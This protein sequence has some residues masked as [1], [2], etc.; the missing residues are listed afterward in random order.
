VGVNTCKGEGWGLVNFEHAACRVAQVVPDHTSCKEIFEGYGRLIRC[1]HVDVDTNFARE[2]P[3]PSAVHL[4][5]ILNELYEDRDKLDAVAELCYLR[6]TDDQ[7]N[8][9]TVAAQFD[10]VFQEV[11]NPPK[12]E[13]ALESKKKSKKKG[14]VK[15]QKLAAV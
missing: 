8:W 5:E 1:D 6:A 13:V 15:D 3:C 12:E 9:D 14:K 11:L 10:G 2:M 7:F 4:T